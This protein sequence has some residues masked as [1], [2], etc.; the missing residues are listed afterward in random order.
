MEVARA[1][2]IFSRR[3]MNSVEWHVSAYGTGD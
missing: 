3:P 1:Q 2:L